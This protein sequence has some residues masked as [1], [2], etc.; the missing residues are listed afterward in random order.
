MAAKIKFKP[1]NQKFFVSNFHHLEKI[2]LTF[3]ENNDVVTSFAGEKL[4]FT[5]KN[6][7]KHR[8][9]FSLGSYIDASIRRSACLRSLFTNT[10]RF[11]SGYV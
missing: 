9:L 8:R 1:L 11:S 3:S 2:L 4:I 7:S 6:E 5:T 10:A